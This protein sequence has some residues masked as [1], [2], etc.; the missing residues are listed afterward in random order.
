MNGQGRR[1]LR[2]PDSLWWKHHSNDPY[3]SYVVLELRASPL[4]TVGGYSVCARRF[5]WVPI[6]S[7]ARL[8]AERA[9]F[10]VWQI[11]FLRQ[12]SRYGYLVEAFVADSWRR[13]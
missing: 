5:P 7:L 9:G 6:F 1:L 3:L 13:P 2:K 4:A 11:R 8:T 12:G 10:L